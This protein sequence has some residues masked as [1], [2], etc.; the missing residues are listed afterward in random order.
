MTYIRAFQIFL[1]LASI[2][3]ASYTAEKLTL[4]N[5]AAQTVLYQLEAMP[6]D[7][8]SLDIA[9]GDDCFMNGKLNVHKF[10]SEP[11]AQSANDAEQF[12]IV[13]LYVFPNDR[14]CRSKKRLTFTY[15]IPA[16]AGKH[17]LVYLSLEKPLELRN[18][19]NVR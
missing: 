1:V 13:H 9:A 11:A 16:E 10:V 17:L 8:L 19:V 4:K 12:R 7:G 2:S 5:G 14:N 3:Q 15:S 18:M 6:G